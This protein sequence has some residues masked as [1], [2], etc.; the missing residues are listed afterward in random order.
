MFLMSFSSSENAFFHSFFI[1]CSQNDKK[2][3]SLE[4][5]KGKH[6]WKPVWV[7]VCVCA[8]K[9]VAKNALFNSTRKCILQF[10]WFQTKI[11]L[12]HERVKQTTGEKKSI[13]NETPN[14]LIINFFSLFYF[15]CCYARDFPF[16]RVLS[17]NKHIKKSSVNHMSRNS[18]IALCTKMTR[19][20]K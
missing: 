17:N 6:Q 12:R 9:L 7:C 10:W 4:N 15:Y 11:P 5:A 3:E 13:K 18:E 19:K 8:H 1:H 14:M 16:H 2:S 20:K